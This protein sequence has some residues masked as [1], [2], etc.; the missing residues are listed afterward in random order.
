MKKTKQPYLKP[1]IKEQKIKINYFLM[2]NRVSANEE[3]L[4]AAEIS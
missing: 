3:L 1:K 2:R 4:L